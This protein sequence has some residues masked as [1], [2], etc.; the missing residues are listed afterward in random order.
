MIH[1][2]CVFCK[3]N[4]TTSKLSHLKKKHRAKI[5]P[6][7]KNETESLKYFRRRKI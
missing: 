1:T 5:L 4:I 2:I 3:R 6:F 7:P